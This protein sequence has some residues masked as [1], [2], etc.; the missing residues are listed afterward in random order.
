MGFKKVIRRSRQIG[1]L[2]AISILALLCSVWNIAAMKKELSLSTQEYCDGI[3][4]QIAKE[5]R[6]GVDNKKTELINVA[7]SIPEVYE[8]GREDKLD[9]FFKRRAE[10]LDF[11]AMILIDDRGRYIAGT[12]RSGME[13]SCNSEKRQ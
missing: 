9:Q 8:R 12:I 11:D 1:I 6:D 2:L 3:T 10:I 4:R 5:I 7:D 13:H